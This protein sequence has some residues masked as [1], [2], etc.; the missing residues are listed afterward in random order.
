MLS[1][2]VKLQKIL[3]LQCFFSKLDTDVS[4]DSQLNPKKMLSS[5]NW[6]HSFTLPQLAAA[7]KCADLLFLLLQDGHQQQTEKLQNLIH[8]M[9]CGDY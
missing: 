8:K 9:D 1:W 6:L 3:E 7:T 5:R 2:W 4:I